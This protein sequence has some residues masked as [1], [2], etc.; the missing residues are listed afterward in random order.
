[1]PY[2]PPYPV[3]ACEAFTRWGQRPTR[4]R[5]RFTTSLRARRLL[6]L[7]WEEQSATDRSIENPERGLCV[8]RT[9]LRDVSG[10]FAVRVLSVPGPG[11]V[12]FAPIAR[13]VLTRFRWLFATGDSRDAEILALRH[14]VL[15]LQR[16]VNRPRFTETDRTILAVL[17]A[18][19]P[20][21]PPTRPARGPPRQ[22][23]TC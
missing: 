17:A 14:Q 18:T 6:V 10:R 22:R 12:L 2:S 15:V 8:P 16:H 13:L 9:H 19:S 21:S 23:A 4:H 7:A 3:I 20:G 11:Q 1:M 5:R